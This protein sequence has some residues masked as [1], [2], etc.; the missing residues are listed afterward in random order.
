MELMGVRT[1]QRLAAEIDAR[2]HV[3]P[4][5]RDFGR[6]IREVGMKEAL[7]ERDAPFGR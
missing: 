6:R 2:G 5:A 4:G 3:A 1:M 7:R